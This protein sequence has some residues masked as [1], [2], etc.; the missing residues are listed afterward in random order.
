MAFN[1][2]KMVHIQCT[3]AIP[4]IMSWWLNLDAHHTTP[5]M[6][7]FYSLNWTWSPSALVFLYTTQWEL[8]CFCKSNKTSTGFK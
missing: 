4:F 3:W 7:L 1:K 5:L 8:K 6:F 2:L